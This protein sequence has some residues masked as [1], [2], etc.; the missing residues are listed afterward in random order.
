M[1]QSCG[2]DLALILDCDI[3]IASENVICRF[4]GDQPGFVSG[5]ALSRRGFNECRRCEP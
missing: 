5:S 2:G 4:A 1:G 3:I